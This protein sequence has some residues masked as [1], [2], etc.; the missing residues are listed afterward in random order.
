MTNKSNVKKLI[1]FSSIACAWLLT[2]VYG[3][4]SKDKRNEEKIEFSIKNRELRE[5]IQKEKLALSDKFHKK[6]LELSIKMQKQKEN[7]WLFENG[8]TSSYG[9]KP[10]C[11]GKGSCLPRPSMSLQHDVKEQF[12]KE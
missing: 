11:D 8:F 12:R 3:I 2:E 9:T 1:F 5:R 10:G 4:W 6:N 7:Q